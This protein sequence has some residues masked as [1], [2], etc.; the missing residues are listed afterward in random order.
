MVPGGDAE[1]V[2]EKLKQKS[3]RAEILT[4]DSDHRTL[5]GDLRNDAIVSTAPEPFFSGIVSKK[6]KNLTVL[7][8]TK[9]D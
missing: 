6:A 3:I 7:V 9:L 5:P 8:I 1:I 2:V 4:L